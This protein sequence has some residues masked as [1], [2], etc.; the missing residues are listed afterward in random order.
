MKSSSASFIATALIAVLLI[1]IH[2]R[3]AFSATSAK[4]DTVSTEKES[5]WSKFK[6]PE[7]GAF[8]L[9]HLISGGVGFVPIL[10][11]ITE[12][13]VGFGLGGALL[14]IHPSKDAGLTNDGRRIPPSISM[15]GGGVTENGTWGA[16]VGHMGVWKQGKIRYLGGLLYADA[17]LEFYGTAS[18][19]G[20][21]SS[22]VSWNVK[23][24]G[25]LQKLQYQ[26]RPGL[27]VGGKYLFLSTKNT[28]GIGNAAY[29]IP[30][31]E[32]ESRLGGL[33]AGVM[34][35]GRDNVFTPD[36]GLFG[37]ISFTRFDNI[38]GGS[39]DYNRLDIAAFGYFEIGPVVLG[40][41]IQGAATGEDAPFYALPFIIQRGIPVFRY[42]GRYAA[43]GEV[44]PRWKVTSRWSLVG[45]VGAGFIA[46]DLDG[47]FDAEAKVAGGGGFRYLLVRRLGMGIGIDVAR[48]PEETAFYIILGS[49]WRST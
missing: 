39:F 46:Q 19:N 3:P 48:G 45:F 41:R 4:A 13:A 1:A 27:F 43:M 20:S 11:P 44:E 6:D 18:G 29:D 24:G 5:F 30:D 17:N 32:T 8:D 21:S 31:A 35:D 9:G 12:P 37:E 7:D 26:L 38:F 14:Y 23:A 49:Y 40:T 2:G 42:L 33:G 16:A 10:V 47:L 15:L 22:S 36:K 28:L 25:T 34:W